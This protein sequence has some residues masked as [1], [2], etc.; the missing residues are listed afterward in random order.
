MLLNSSGRN[1]TVSVLAWLSWWAWDYTRY[2]WRVWKESPTL[3]IPTFYADSALMIA[4][5]L[6]GAYT[7]WHLYRNVRALATDDYRGLDIHE[8][9]YQAIALDSSEEKSHG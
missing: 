2:S 9:D 4:L 7:V 5:V 3:Y 8:T 1:Q 6:M